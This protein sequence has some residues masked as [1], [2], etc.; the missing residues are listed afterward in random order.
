M[1]LYKHEYH[2]YK[3]QII[4][5]EFEVEEKPKT[6]IAA[7]RKDRFFDIRIRKDEINKLSGTF[8]NRMFTLTPDP[9][10]FI[11]ALIEKSER[12]INSLKDRLERAVAYKTELLKL[13]EEKR[14]KDDELSN[15]TENQ[16]QITDIY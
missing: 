4:T 14:S 1:K 12:N 3:K 13:T 2:E 7:D 6:Y 9:T 11:D 8:S 10:M 16:A 15:K 5:T